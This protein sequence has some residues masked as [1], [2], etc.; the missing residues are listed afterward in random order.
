MENITEE[1]LKKD[2]EDIYANVLYVADLPKETTN[3]DLQKLFQGYHYQFASLNNIKNNTTWAQVYLEN[4]ECAKKARHELNGTILTPSN[5]EGITKGKPIRICKYEGRGAIRKNNIKQSLLVKNIDINMTQK[6]FYNIFLKY[7]DIVS[8]K[9]EYDENGI[10]KGFG[11]IYYYTEES[12]EEAKKNL[13]GQSYFGKQLEIVNLIPGKKNKSNTITLFV[14][15]LPSDITEEK[16]NLIFGQFGP[17]SNI[18]INPK[19]GYAYVSYNNFESA[20]KC[21]TEMKNNPIS[22]PGL[23]NIVVKNATTKEERESNRNFISNNMGGNDFNQANLCI[24]FNY[25]YFND[26]I[27][28]DLDLDK[29]IRLFIKVIMLMDYCPKEVLVDLESMSG[30]VIFGN[31]SDYGMFFKKYQEFCTKQYPYFECVP[32][33]M[34]LPNNDGPNNFNNINSSQKINQMM[35]PGNNNSNPPP[36]NQFPNDYIQMMNNMNN[37]QGRNNSF[38]NGNMGM[39]PNMIMNQNNLNNMNNRMLMN[40]GLNYMNNNLQRNFNYSNNMNYKN[41][42]GQ[43]MNNNNRSKFNNDKNKNGQKYNNNNRK[44][45]QRQ[46]MPNNNSKYIFR[47]N[48]GN[49]YNININMPQN[50]MPINPLIQQ[51]MMM[52]SKQNNKKFNNN[53]DRFNKVMNMGNSMNFPPRNYFSLNQNNNDF[54]DNNNYMNN[55]QNEKNDNELIDQRNLQNLNPSQLLSQFNKPPINY[56]GP[57]MLNSKEQEDLVNEIADSIYEIVYGKYPKDASKITGMIKEKGYEKMNM[58]LSK[59]EDLNEMIDK[60]HE[61]INNSRN[62]NKTENSDSK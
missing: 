10:S 21:L 19:G 55:F 27:K 28:S 4:K 43:I 53:N 7:G 48:Y 62:N 57:N 15:N 14:L 30:L 50:M 32:Y 17:V 12:A 61:M 42:Y 52:L 3:E 58:L 38:L 22:F 23:P 2:N 39:P 13:N 36:F 1:N 56:N 54:R 31:I 35:T 24:Q 25:L 59:P 49:S 6:E 8:G 47:Q 46:N 60:A 20:S 33:Q 5:C 11:Y 44:M 41:N 34:P 40:N 9:I 18:S 37:M 26:E 51:Q 29:E 16:L 45:M